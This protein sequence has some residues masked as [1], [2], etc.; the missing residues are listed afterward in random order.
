MSKLL[1]DFLYEV[2]DEIG[3]NA[4]LIITDD[5]VSEKLAGLVKNKDL[6]RYIL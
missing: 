5:M 6:S 2:P 1:N 4:K 3:P